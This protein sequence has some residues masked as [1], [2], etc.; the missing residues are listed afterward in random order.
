MNYSSDAM[1]KLVGHRYGKARV[2]VLKILREG[3][4]HQI[5]DLD[6]KALLHGDFELSYTSG[7]NSTVAATDSIKN[8]INILAKQEIGTE[9]E[10]LALSLG[11]HLLKKYPQVESKI[12]DIAEREWT[13]M[14]TKGIAQPHAF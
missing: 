10:R 1:P 4:R 6:V 12:R 7:H 5:K 2:R 8:T 13:R 14:N 9:I 3:K 11:E